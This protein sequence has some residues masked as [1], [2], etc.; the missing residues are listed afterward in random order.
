MAFFFIPLMT[1]TLSGL[2]PERIA[3][4]SGL[5]NF[6][7]ITA[8]AFGTSIATTLWQ[9]RS[10]LHHAQLVEHLQ[11]G[12][13]ALDGTLAGLQSQGWSLAQSLGL[14]ERLTQQQ[15]ATRAADDIFLASAVLFVLLIPLVYLTHP[16]HG[17]ANATK[18]SAGGH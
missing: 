4:A 1:I 12:R 8:G 5:S 2:P 7:R 6:T 3:A 14:V 15:A 11:I 9:D 10:T 16:T 18:D 17:P 13:A